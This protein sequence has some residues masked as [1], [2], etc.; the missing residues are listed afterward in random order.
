M[1]LTCRFSPSLH[2][3][4]WK[5]RLYILREKLLGLEKSAASK[6]LAPAGECIFDRFWRDF[7]KQDTNLA[8][9]SSPEDAKMHRRRAIRFGSRSANLWATDKQYTLDV[10]DPNTCLGALSDL[11][12]ADGR[13]VR[14]ENPTHSM[15]VFGDRARAEA[16]AKGELDVPS[17]TAPQSCYGKLY[18]MGGQVLLVGV[19]HARNTY[20][21]AVDEMM[22]LP[23]RITDTP[24][25]VRIRRASGEVATRQIRTHRSTLTPDISARFPKYETAF[26]YH[27]AITDGFL[28][29]APVQACNARIMKEVM[30]LIQSRADRDPLSDEA[31]L[32]PV[33]YVRK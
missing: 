19:S 25:E 5:Y 15:V 4:S 6:L 10:C 13:G 16:F 29:N 33:W 3:F 32:P 27:G 21:H 24:T 31:A 7:A 8:S 11:A 26:R 28:G 2:L 23:N 30:E 20:L 22:D 12:V 14:T 1:V 9:Q 17:G 18:E